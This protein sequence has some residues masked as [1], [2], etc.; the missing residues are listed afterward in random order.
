M[1]DRTRD[2]YTGEPGRITGFARI[3]GLPAPEDVD[4]DE[5]EELRISLAANRTQNG[6]RAVG[7]KL[8][9]TSNRLAFRPHD[10]D[11]ALCGRSATVPLSDVASV[12]V[13]PATRDVATALRNPLATLF[14]G[15][16]TDRLRIETTDGREELFVVGDERGLVDRIADLL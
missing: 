9:V 15:A 11:A 13:E 8:F 1:N 7:G 2:V 14:G 16:L 10:F 3:F 12:G 6:R 5:G 4:L